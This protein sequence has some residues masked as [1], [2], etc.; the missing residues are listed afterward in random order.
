MTKVVVDV[1]LKEKNLSK[2]IVNS[3]VKNDGIKKIANFAI[4]NENITRGVLDFAFKHKNLVKKAAN[5][6]IK[7]KDVINNENAN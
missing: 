6:A 7:N 4:E 3:Y 2:N 1:A 5:F